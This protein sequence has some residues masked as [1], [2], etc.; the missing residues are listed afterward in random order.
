MPL[1]ETGFQSYTLLALLYAGFAAA[2]LF[3]LLFPLL[4]HASLPLRLF[5]ETLFAAALAVLAAASLALTGCGAPRLYMPFAMA[6]GAAV[7]RLGLHRV[8]TGLINI[9][10]KNR[11]LRKERE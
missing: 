10:H 3:D 11:S 6:A 4:N 1:W 2:F 9:F 8:W 7:Y 5:G